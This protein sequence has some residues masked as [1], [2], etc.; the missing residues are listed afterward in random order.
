[1]PAKLGI[2]G[3]GVMGEAL[4]SCLLSKGMYTPDAILVSDL[5]HERRQLL[6][7]Q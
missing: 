1:M 6:A 2:I 3:G 5:S 4:L 7:E